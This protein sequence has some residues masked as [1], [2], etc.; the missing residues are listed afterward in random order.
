MTHRALTTCIPQVWSL[1]DNSC[2]ASLVGPKKPV[3]AMKLRAQGRLLLAASGRKI[4]VWD[5]QH[6][7]LLKARAGLGVGKV[8]SWER[9][10]LATGKGVFVEALR[11]WRSTGPI[12]LNM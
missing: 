11:G 10:W 3:I 9:G 1:A 12:V 8:G 5:V 7:K 4:R 6:F 2:I